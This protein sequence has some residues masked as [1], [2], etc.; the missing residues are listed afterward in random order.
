MEGNNSEYNK[1]AGGITVILA[2]GI[3]FLLINGIRNPKP[4]IPPTPKTK[5]FSVNT[6]KAAPPLDTKVI[7]SLERRGDYLVVGIRVV[8]D[9]LPI[10]RKMMVYIKDSVGSI[11]FVDSLKIDLKTK[12]IGV[13]QSSI[14]ISNAGPPPYQV[15]TEWE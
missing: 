13:S 6:D 14:K 5:S 7:S 9:G 4:I 12:E 10:Q 3:L 8:N 15:V 2:V 11:H 1:I